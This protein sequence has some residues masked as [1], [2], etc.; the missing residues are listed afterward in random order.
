[1]SEFNRQKDQAQQLRDK[2]SEK[3][4]ESRESLDILAL[5]PRSKVHHEKDEKKKTKLKLKFPLLRLLTILIVL[6]PIA[7]L[8]YTYHEKNQIPTTSSIHREEPSHSE[9]ISIGSKETAPKE[10]SENKAESEEELISNDT[11]ESNEQ[12]D[13]S[14]GTG[15]P[16]VN[17]E[18]EDVI[19]HVVQPDE[20]L[21]TISQL[22]FKSREGEQLIMEWN[23]LEQNKVEPGQELEIPVI[24]LNSK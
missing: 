17:N 10:N 1:M 2:M 18:N 5:P 14:T 21:Y 23:N 11:T 8:G 3:N 20:T 24:Q 9:K 12:T 22:Y 16:S 13:V 15:K 19:I 6:L 7:I 4:Q